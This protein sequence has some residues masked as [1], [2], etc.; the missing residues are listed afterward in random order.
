MFIAASVGCS[1]KSDP[2]PV[3]CYLASVSSTYESGNKTS[4]TYVYNDKNQLV[5]VTDSSTGVTDIYTYDGSG[6]I[7]QIGDRTFSYDANNRVVKLEDKFNVR[8]YAYNGIGQLISH[9][10]EARVSPTVRYTKKLE[11]LNASTQNYTKAT[12]SQTIISNSI[13][14]TTGVTN[15][16]YDTKTNPYKLTIPVSLQSDNNIVKISTTSGSYTQIETFTYQYNERGYPI[17]SLY[18]LSNNNGYKLTI[19]NTY[20][21]MCK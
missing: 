19:S 6:K 18:S 2:A 17:S 7:T 1:E 4:S 8:S 9:V 13:T 16:E 11:Y 10:T 21:Y 20:S 14:S 15:Y 5:S 3:I 12:F